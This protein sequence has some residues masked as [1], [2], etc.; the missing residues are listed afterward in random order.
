MAK[1]MKLLEDRTRKGFLK[2]KEDHGKLV[3]EMRQIATPTPGHSTEESA[4]IKQTC[5]DVKSLSE[6]FNA[7]EIEAKAA[8][9]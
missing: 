7:F 5:I 9:E 8:L 6:K 4:L 2:V 3:Q 1:D